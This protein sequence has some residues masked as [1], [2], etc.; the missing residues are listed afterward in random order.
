VA[1]RARISVNSHF[2]H[3]NNCIHILFIHIFFTH[4]FFIQISFFIYIFSPTHIS[5]IRIF[6][7]LIIF[8]TIS[9]FMTFQ[10]FHS[11]NIYQKT[12]LNTTWTLKHE[13]YTIPTYG[14]CLC[15]LLGFFFCVLDIP[16]KNLAHI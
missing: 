6:L 11:Y 5:F 13:S 2:I 1:C 7:M 12:F 14:Q 9:I 16:Q 3:S 4:V 8:I 10:N 15:Y